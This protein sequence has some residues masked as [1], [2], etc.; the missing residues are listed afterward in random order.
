MKPE[1]I[2]K[3]MIEDIRAARAESEAGCSLELNADDS[4]A[5][6]DCAI[7]KYAFERL[8]HEFHFDTAQEM[9]EFLQ[10][11]HDFLSEPL[12]AE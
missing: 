7:R 5:F 11:A 6:A 9:G 2:I 3:K 10:V 8:I 1:D 12:Q 4:K